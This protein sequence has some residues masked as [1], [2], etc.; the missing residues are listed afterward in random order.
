[1]VDR[2]LKGGN[3]FAKSLP[4]AF[5]SVVIRIPSRR[6]NAQFSRSIPAYIRS[7]TS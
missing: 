6:A 2:F 1:V 5:D 3:A 7:V 4:A